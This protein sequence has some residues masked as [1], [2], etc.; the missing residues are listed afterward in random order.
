MNGVAF[1]LIWILH[2][3]LSFTISTS[4]AIG[5]KKKSTQSYSKRLSLRIPQ[6]ANRLGKKLEQSATGSF[7][8]RTCFMRL[9]YTYAANFR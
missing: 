6:T 8:Y 1:Q 4:R 7:T 5:R 2:L 9:I 3:Y